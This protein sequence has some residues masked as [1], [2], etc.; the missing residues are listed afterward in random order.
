MIHRGTN[1][2]NIDEYP[3]MIGHRWSLNIWMIKDQTCSLIELWILVLTLILLI[4]GLDLTLTE[5]TLPGRRCRR[6]PVRWPVTL[7]V[8]KLLISLIFVAAS[9]EDCIGNNLPKPA[10]SYLPDLYYVLPWPMKYVQ[11]FQLLMGLSKFIG[12]ARREAEIGPISPEATWAGTGT[13]EIWKSSCKRNFRCICEIPW[14]CFLYFFR[15][16]PN[17]PKI[18]VTFSNGM[19][20]HSLQT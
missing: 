6:R 13:T 14:K 16:W 12:F 1:G 15:R 8:S 9:I 11:H 17:W 7:K 10:C 18:G 4:F 2:T 3:P 5:V 20:L 19:C